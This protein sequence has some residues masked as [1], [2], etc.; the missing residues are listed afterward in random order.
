MITNTSCPQCFMGKVPI[1][2]MD[3]A[4]DELAEKR[5]LNYYE[6]MLKIGGGYE[7]CS[8]CEGTGQIKNK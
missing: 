4:I 5:G 2:E 8:N 7:V 6:A 3:E 1:P